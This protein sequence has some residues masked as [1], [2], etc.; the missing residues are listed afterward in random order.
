MALTD[1]EFYEALLSDYPEI[2]IVDRQKM[3]AAIMGDGPHGKYVHQNEKNRR[4]V[5][6]YKAEDF[7]ASEQFDMLTEAITWLDGKSEGVAF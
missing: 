1:K 6:C 3:V 4:W 2:A 5:A 7:R